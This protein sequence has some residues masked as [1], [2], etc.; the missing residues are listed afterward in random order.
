M[1]NDIIVKCGICGNKILYQG[2]KFVSSELLS[3]RLYSGGIHQDGALFWNEG[4]V[5]PVKQAGNN[6][7]AFLREELIHK[8]TSI[9]EIKVVYYTC[10]SGSVSIPAD[11]KMFKFDS[12]HTESD[13]L[14]EALE[15]LVTK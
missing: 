9:T 14:A 1:G 8:I 10:G 4:E 7:N 3:F 2:K 12:E 15:Y 6:V 11:N 13:A 5:Y